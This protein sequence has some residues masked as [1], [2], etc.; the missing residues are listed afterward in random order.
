MWQSFVSFLRLDQ[1]SNS[2]AD[3]LELMHVMHADGDTAANA[4]I[5]QL[6]GAE[7]K[8]DEA[9]TA[10]LQ[11]VE[12]QTAGTQSVTEKQACS[13]VKRYE[14]CQLVAMDC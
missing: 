9:M 5:N 12:N 13:T 3:A 6:Q 8:A 2:S 11:S 4:M 10:E 14:V 7:T 1:A